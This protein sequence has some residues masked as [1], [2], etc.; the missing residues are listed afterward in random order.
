MA[1]VNQISEAYPVQ[2]E[3]VNE[4]VIE[5]MIVSA[6]ELIKH[7]ILAPY[8]PSHVPTN[9]VIERAVVHQCGSWLEFGESADLGGF[10][11]GT[12]FTVGQTTIPMPAEVCPRSLRVLRSAGLLTPFGA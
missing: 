1:T 8:N 10:P 11:E 2:A 5:Q 4:S 3:G 6:E 9:D 12:E 7:T